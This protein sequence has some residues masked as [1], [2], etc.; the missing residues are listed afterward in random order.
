MQSINLPLVGPA[1][2]QLVSQVEIKQ[3]QRHTQDHMRYTTRGGVGACPDSQVV[4]RD[5]GDARQ[6][7]NGGW[8]SEYL[9]RNTGNCKATGRRIDV[10]PARSERHCIERKS[11]RQHTISQ[12]W[13][14]RNVCN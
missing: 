8:S 6:N 10:G 4:C 3:R 11:K 1:S 12:N 13:Q 7:G 9:V 14:R 5:R 2:Q